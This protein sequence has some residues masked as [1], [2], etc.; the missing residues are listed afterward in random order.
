MSPGPTP[1]HRHLREV[2]GSH[3]SLWRLPRDTH[4]LVLLVAEAQFAIDRGLDPVDCFEMNR[5]Y[6][7][8]IDS[9]LRESDR[10]RGRD[11]NY[12]RLPQPQK[13]VIDK[14]D[15]LKLDFVGGMAGYWHLEDPNRE[16]LGDYDPER[17]ISEIYHDRPWSQPSP[18]DLKSSLQHRLNLVIDAD[19]RNL[20]QDWLVSTG[21]VN[22]VQVG[23]ENYKHQI[24]S[25]EDSIAGAGEV[26]AKIRSSV[27]SEFQ[28]SDQTL[29]EEHLLLLRRTLANAQGIYTRASQLA[30]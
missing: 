15:K 9:R 18:A 5:Q 25:L 26:I 22:P 24:G 27:Q 3:E 28:A 29:V 23:Y 7:L 4:R 17:L 6:W 16:L 12:K 20:W 2:S 11:E 14:L 21:R 1:E 10:E 30:A 8:Q 13:H 19:N